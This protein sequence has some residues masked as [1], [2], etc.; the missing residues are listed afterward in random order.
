MNPDFSEWYYAPLKNP[1]SPAV[2][3]K[4]YSLEKD[5]NNYQILKNDSSRHYTFYGGDLVGVK[6]KIPYLK[7]LGITCI[8][9]NP[10]VQAASNHKYDTFDYLQIDPHFG[11]N[12]VFKDLVKECHEN[13]ISIILDFAFNHVGTGFFAF[14]DCLKN[15]RKSKYYD[16]FDWY[17]FPLPKQ[18]PFD[19]KAS[20]YYQCWWGHATLPDLNFDLKRFHPEENYIYDIEDAEA[21]Q[22][23]I[24]YLL[25]VVEFWLMEMDIDGF[26][27]DVPNE[28]PFWFW[29]L[30]R[31][32]VK[33]LK[34]DAYLI[35]EIWHN[36]EEWIGDYFDAVMNYS[37]FR[38]PVLQY[39]AL[40]NWSKQ[41]FMKE[42]MQGLH[43][44]GFYNLSLMMNVVSS[45]DTYR[46]LQACDG[47]IRKLK[48]ALLYQMSWIGVPHL[49]YGDEIGMKGGNDPDNRRPMNWGFSENLDLQ[50]LH[51]FVQK[52]IAIRKSNQVLVYG[53]ISIKE[54][55]QDLIFFE[56]KSADKRI[57][58]VINPTAQQKVFSFGSEI[59]ITDL[60]ENLN[61]N[62]S[63]NSKNIKLKPFSGKLFKEID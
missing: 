58:V 26:R 50:E 13:G 63:I 21:N 15:G 1:L 20:D 52:L 60:I 16:W 53:D 33:S 4:M 14:Q 54:N 6:Q 8:Y 55:Y 3:Q 47:D 41:Q 5:W 49:F 17:R 38:E 44:Y 23:L 35:G 34:S 29:K 27:L 39:F 18:I 42:M 2:Q 19:F 9:F 46:F 30:F 43:S 59:H 56:R 48:L 22:P 37:F 51:D 32:K 31:N 57:F 25:Q 10:L 12:Q 61:K 28:V 62:R 24:N 40:Q 7:A 45:H 36:A 11:G